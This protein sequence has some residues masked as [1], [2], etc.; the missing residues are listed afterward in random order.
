MTPF[1][2]PFD[3]VKG[4]ERAG[5]FFQLQIFSDPNI[6]VVILL[7]ATESKA[8]KAQRGGLSKKV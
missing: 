1:R 2:P 8:R 4:S 5:G 6:N 7:S 3:S